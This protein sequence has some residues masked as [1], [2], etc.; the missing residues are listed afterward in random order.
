MKKALVLSCIIFLFFQ[1]DGQQNKPED[2]DQNYFITHNREDL[3]HK[4]IDLPCDIKAD[5]PVKVI[6]QKICSMHVDLNNRVHL[7]HT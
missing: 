2:S 4:L 1:L 5:D 6:F 3:I 7:K